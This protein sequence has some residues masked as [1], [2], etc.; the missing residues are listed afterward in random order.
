MQVEL[1][2]SFKH[3][4]TWLQKHSNCFFFHIYLSLFILYVACPLCVVRFNIY[5]FGL[6][7]YLIYTYVVS[8]VWLLFVKELRLGDPCLSFLRWF[9]FNASKKNDV[10]I[11]CP[12]I[13]PLRFC[14]VKKRT[15]I[16]RNKY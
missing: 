14:I 9:L 6:R 1:G 16:L 8:F 2:F 4:T 10:P 15:I 12:N 3:L 11:K 5:F 13:F 7:C